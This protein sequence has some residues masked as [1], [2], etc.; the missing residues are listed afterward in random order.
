MANNIFKKKIYLY[1]YGA[2][3]NLRCKILILSYYVFEL[4]KSINI[5]PL[6][7]FDCLIFPSIPPKD[8]IKRMY[9]DELVVYR[10]MEIGLFKN[11]KEIFFP[12]NI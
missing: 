6:I 2:K 8:S 1:S 5:D 10:G 12:F 11:H 3:I 7:K 9:I 4:L